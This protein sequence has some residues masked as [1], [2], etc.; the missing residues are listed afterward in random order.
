MHVTANCTSEF[1]VEYLGKIGRSNEEGL[2]AKNKLRNFG[3]FLSIMHVPGPTSDERT[4]SLQRTQLLQLN[5][6]C[7]QSVLYSEV[8]L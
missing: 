1:T 7:P 3:D 6:Y 8:P 5:L 4:T 2:W